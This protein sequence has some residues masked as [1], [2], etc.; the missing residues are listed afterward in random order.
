MARSRSTP[1]LGDQHNN[2]LLLQM[3]C[4]GNVS[5]PCFNTLQWVFQRRLSDRE[6]LIILE[7][8]LTVT[9]HSLSHSLHMLWE[10]LWLPREGRTSLA[11]KL[12]S[13]H[14]IS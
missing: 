13:G 5:E 8:A 4:N 6:A 11:E 10:K 3:C 7:V 9:L 14:L 1:A 2:I 12:L